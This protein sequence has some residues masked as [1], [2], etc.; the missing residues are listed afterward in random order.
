MEYGTSEADLQAAGLIDPE[1]QE[2]FD[3]APDP[4]TRPDV[5]GTDWRPVPLYMTQKLLGEI[6]AD[7]A[8][9]L[10]AQPPTPDAEV[11]PS[12]Q[13]APEPPAG[14]DVVMEDE[15]ETAARPDNMAQMQ[16]FSN[17]YRRVHAYNTYI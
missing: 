1:V 7:Q 5:L 6:T 12:S 17:R 13:H 11:P 10:A 15:Q 9:Q 16:A 4:A 2:L 14:L 3:P 8:R